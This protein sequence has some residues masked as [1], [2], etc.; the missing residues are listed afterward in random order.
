MPNQKQTNSQSQKSQNS[1]ISE[2]DLD[3]LTLQE[4]MDL[5]DRVDSK[6]SASQFYRMSPH[7]MILEYSLKARTRNDIIHDAVG[8]IQLTS[9]LHPRLLPT[10][11]SKVELAIAQQVLD[12]LNAALYD[13]CSQLEDTRLA[14]GQDKVIPPSTFSTLQQTGE[15]GRIGPP[16]DG[17]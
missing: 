14:D 13:L 3:Q 8:V 6:L 4:L 16:F 11:T 15:Q 9:L 1:N 10:A 2:I 7:D 17:N 12:P 5:K